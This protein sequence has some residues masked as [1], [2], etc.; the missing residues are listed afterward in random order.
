[1]EIEIKSYNLPDISILN[2]E[3]WPD[4]QFYTWIPDRYYLI[5]GLSN[6]ID[7]SLK[8]EAV[9][10]DKVPVL[11]R[12][13]GGESVILSSKTLVISTCVKT[14][15]FGNPHLYFRNINTLVMEKLK[16]A[17]IQNLNHKGISDI[18]IGDKKILGS[19]IYRKKNKLFYHAVLNVS[20]PV[21][22]IEKYLKHPGK[23]PD[24]RKGRSHKDFVTSLHQEGYHYT[25]EQLATLF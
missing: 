9:I 17:G 14:Q 20:E 19:S 13:S 16:N 3:Q 24:Y 10:R 22:T 7:K 25:P 21:E 4:Y 8:K 11:K 23:E 5:L 6:Q 12:P 1:M 15:G 2:D 18:A